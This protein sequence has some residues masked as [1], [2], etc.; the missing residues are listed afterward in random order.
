MA[1]QM[2]RAIAHSERPPPPIPSPCQ[3]HARLLT[4]S[5]RSRLTRLSWSERPPVPVRIQLVRKRA[6][7]E[8][9]NA[10]PPVRSRIETG[11]SEECKLA[12]QDVDRPHR[13][14]DQVV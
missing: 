13:G 6:A 10:H 8:Q 2:L 4:P 5:S 7:L 3:L 9:G 1:N 11:S 12:S 14:I